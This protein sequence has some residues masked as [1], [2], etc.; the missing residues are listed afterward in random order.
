MNGTEHSPLSANQVSAKID[1]AVEQA[2]ETL[3]EVSHAIHDKPELAFEEHFACEVLAKT[4]RDH[5]LSVATGVYSLETAFETTINS[6]QVGPTVAVL[7]EYD[8]LPQIG[9]ACGHNVI[10]TSALGATLALDVVAAF[11]PGR[12]KLL[13]TPAEER[14]GGKELMAREGAFEGIDAAL[15]IHPAGV[16]LATMPS[17]CVA[18]VEVVYHGRSSHAS[19]MPHKGINALDGL[20]LAYQ[21]ISNLRQHIR[22]TERIHGIV[23]EGGA[24]PNIVPDRTVGQFYV[25]AANEKELAALKP[26]VQACFEAGATGSGCTVEVNWAGVDYLD[27]NTNWP[28]AERFRHYAE[29]LGREFIDDDQALKFGAGSTDMGNVS[30]RLP[31]IHPML[32]VAPPNVVIHHPDFARWARSEKG[33]AAVIDGAKALAFTAAEYLLSPQLQRQCGAAFELSKGLA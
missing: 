19:A 23:Q 13:G 32:A 21:A 24:A 5:N 28:L 16:N 14:G 3:L 25:R 26:R 12:V 11:L 7:A 6:E 8:A 2:A 15:M 31:S 29:Q 22:S 9:H 10:A 18:E 33:D 1:A 20:L 27:I 17:I 30:Y 4:L